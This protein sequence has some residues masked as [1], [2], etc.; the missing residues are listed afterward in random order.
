MS[1]AQKGRYDKCREG[2]EQAHPGGVDQGQ[3]E[4]QEWVDLVGEEWEAPARV[5]VLEENVSA[6]NVELQSLMRLE[7][8]VPRKFAPNAGEQ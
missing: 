7:F 5:L 3:E 1:Q 8:P 6:R 4:K 2:M